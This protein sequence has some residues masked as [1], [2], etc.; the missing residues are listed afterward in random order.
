[1]RCAV[2][3][4]AMDQHE[5]ARLF[6]VGSALFFIV[7]VLVTYILNITRTLILIAP[8]RREMEP[9]SVWSLL[10]PV[11]NLFFNYF[12]V[13]RLANSLESEYRS[14]KWEFR[15]DDFGRL[16]G[17]VMSTAWWVVALSQRQAALVT[18]LVGLVAM[19]CTISYGLRIA[20]YRRRLETE[21]PREISG[22]SIDEEVATSNPF[23]N[24]A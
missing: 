14:R 5:V 7:M 6:L 3:A 22:E 20:G 19:G 17:I 12:V 8:S 1:M 16:L 2:F 23:E 24:L 10:V 21:S 9:R 18:L 15:G 4:D 11:H 13:S